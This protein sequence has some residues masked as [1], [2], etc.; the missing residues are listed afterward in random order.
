M[1]N[2][3]I[4]TLDPSPAMTRTAQDFTGSFQQAMEKVSEIWRGRPQS[5]PSVHSR[6]NTTFYWFTIRSDGSWTNR[7]HVPTTVGKLT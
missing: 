5:S 3:T 4:T 1:K 6:G 7:N 2:W